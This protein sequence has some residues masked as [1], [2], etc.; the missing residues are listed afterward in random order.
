MTEAAS[1]IV[2]ENSK[3]NHK[4]TRVV[5]T[6]LSTEDDDLLQHI[7]TLAYQNGS[8]MEPSKS[9]IVRFFISLCLSAIIKEQP[10]LLVAQKQKQQQ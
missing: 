4:L 10:S 9:E 8:I 6:K 3:K 1:S 2:K 7:T 5:S